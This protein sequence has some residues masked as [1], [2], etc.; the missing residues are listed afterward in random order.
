M[1]AIKE[2]DK[3]S[4]NDAIFFLNGPGST[5]KIMLQIIVMSKLRSQQYVLLAV[6]SFGIAAILLEG[7]R[8]VYF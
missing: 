6:A 3:F 8:T 4:K 1:N 7:R 2:Q 5:K